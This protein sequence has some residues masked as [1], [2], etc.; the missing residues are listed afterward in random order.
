MHSRN[1]VR[2]YTFTVCYGLLML[3]AAIILAVS[4]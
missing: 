3:A 2:G 1:I 4:Q